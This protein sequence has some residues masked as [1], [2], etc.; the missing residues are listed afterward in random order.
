MED[1]TTHFHMS[2]SQFFRKIK[3]LTGLNINQYIKEVKLQ[4]AKELL[5]LNTVYS[6]K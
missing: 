1:L 4:T 6:V 2:R 5:E 3:Q